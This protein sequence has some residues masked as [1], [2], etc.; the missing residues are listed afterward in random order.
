MN[1]PSLYKS[2]DGGVT[3]TQLP[4]TAEYANSYLAVHKEKG[5]LLSANTNGIFRSKD[6]AA[7]F[8][9]VLDKVI[10]S[11]DTIR[12]QPNMVW[13]TACEGIY[14]SE[15]YGDTWT[16]L[17][18]ENYPD[19]HP[20]RIR[21]SP[22]NPNHMVLE[23]DYT[24]KEGNPYGHIHAFSRDGGKTWQSSRKNVCDLPNFSPWRG[25]MSWCE[26]KIIRCVDG[27]LRMLGTRSMARTSFS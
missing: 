3:W 19:F 6:G 25:N 2:T 26:S 11:M 10:F 1:D 5:W 15:D 23:D 8:E 24:T 21:V 22:V 20:D 13:A 12:T 14:I 16:C 7:T 27:R 9:K 17:K 4:D 18:G